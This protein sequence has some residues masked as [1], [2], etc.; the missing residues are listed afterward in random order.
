VFLSEHSCDAV[1]PPPFDEFVA[2]PGSDG[3]P[4]RV[5]LRGHDEY[6]IKFGHLEAAA[7]RLGY[8]VERFPLMDLLGLR[9]D[10]EVRTMARNPNRLSETSEIGDEF[11]HHVAEY[12]ALLL[13]R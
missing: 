9:S 2:L 13:T 3:Y 1:V 11:L 7:Q 8:R 10:D 12:Q 5:P 6:T 4:R